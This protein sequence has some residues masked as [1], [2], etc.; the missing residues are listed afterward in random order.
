MAKKLINA[1][2]IQ[3]E[4]ENVAQA[5]NTQISITLLIDN[6]ANEKLS[7]H[8]RNLFL[9]S[10]P[11][12]RVTI[13]YFDDEYTY[14]NTSDDCAFI[15][16]GTSVCSPKLA[17]DILAHD[18]PVFTIT[19]SLNS[20]FEASRKAGVEASKE[21]CAELRDFTDKS[22]SKLND[23]IGAWI[24]AVLPSK[25]TAFA[26][27]FNFVAHGVAKDCI[28]ITTAQNAALGAL[29]IVP[30]ADFAILSAN[31]IKM[32]IQIASAYGHD[33]D[34]DMLKEIGAVLVCG[35]GFKKV[36]K[37]MKKFVP[38][39]GPFIGAGVAG[40]GTYALGCAILEYFDAGGDIDGVTNIIKKSISGINSLR[41]SS[42][43]KNAIH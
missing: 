13:N 3:L 36:A 27:T 15:V 32:L 28:A 14:S 39:L 26:R 35:F 33:I 41:N 17:K 5:Q 19:D 30:G 37:S 9:T 8:I 34:K 25:E 11:N 6:S 29:P 12:A 21:D 23:R 22:I 42:I 24:C 31:Q 4:I 10:N 7:A 38:V 2:P 18:I 1:K 43:V 16:A 40:G 20:L